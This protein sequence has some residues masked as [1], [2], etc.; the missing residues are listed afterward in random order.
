MSPEPETMGPTLFAATATI[1]PI[2]AGSRQ[3]ATEA[4]SV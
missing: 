1:E 2:T 3:K 4:I